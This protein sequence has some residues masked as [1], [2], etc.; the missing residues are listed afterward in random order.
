[1]PYQDTVNNVGGISGHGD[2]GCSRHCVGEV[3]GC[4][5]TPHSAEGG[6]LRQ[7]VRGAAQRPAQ[8]L[9]AVGASQGRANRR[10]RSPRLTWAGGAESWDVLPPCGRSWNCARGP[11]GAPRRL[12]RLTSGS[13]ASPRGAARLLSAKTAQS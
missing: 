9:A 4:C 12:R 13:R 11:G 5:S 1:M 7:T 2:W 8:S 3:Q 6:T 10:T